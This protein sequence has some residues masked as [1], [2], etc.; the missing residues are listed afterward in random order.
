M[1]FGIVVSFSLY[2]AVSIFVFKAP[3]YS[4]DTVVLFYIN[5]QLG[6]FIA[7]NQVGHSAIIRT[8]CER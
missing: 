1:P 8:I 2:E 3:L 5:D 7:N 6:C 4:F